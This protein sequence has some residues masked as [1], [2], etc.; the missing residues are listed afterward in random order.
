MEKDPPSKPSVAELAG[1]FKGHILPMP[2]AHNEFR[3]RPPCSLKL[4]NPK[5]NSEDSDKTNVPPSSFKIKA[6]NSA[7]I[8]KLQANLA[9]SPTSLLPSPKSPDVNLQPTTS[10]P[11]TLPCSPLSPLSPNLRSSHQSSED[12][13]P[14][15]FSD[16]PEGTPLHSFNKTRARLSFKRRPPTRQHRRSAGDEASLVRGSLSPC[17]LNSPTENGEDPDQVF[18]SPEEDDGHRQP[19]CLLEAEED[20]DSEKVDAVKNEPNEGDQTTQDETRE[21]GEQSSEPYTASQIEGAVK[22]EEMEGME[23]PKKQVVGCEV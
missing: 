14:V 6:K 23:E 20:R 8:E 13:E 7:I 17:E 11:T 22:I 4:H 10:P 3:R 21:R 16:P 9:L 1:K 18:N 15:S 19:A 12:E 5:E 2:S